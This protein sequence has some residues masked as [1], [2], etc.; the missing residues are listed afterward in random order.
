MLLLEAT[1]AFH[2]EGLCM[3]QLSDLFL[4][5]AFLDAIQEGKKVLVSGP[6]CHCLVELCLVEALALLFYVQFHVLSCPLP[7]FAPTFG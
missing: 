7:E 1:T 5:S 2:G 6:L 3:L 4:S